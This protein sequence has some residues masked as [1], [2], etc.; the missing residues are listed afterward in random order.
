MTHWSPVEAAV[1]PG[2]EN[3]GVRCSGPF[4][5]DNLYTGT[6]PDGLGYLYISAKKGGVCGF[7][8]AI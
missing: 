7:M 2:D 5:R 6:T 8:P 3:V 4:V 1:V